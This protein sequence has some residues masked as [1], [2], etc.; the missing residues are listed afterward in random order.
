MKESIRL[1]LAMQRAQ[2]EAEYA[3][4]LAQHDAFTYAMGF[5]RLRPRR[6]EEFR[7]G[8]AVKAAR[9]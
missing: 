4:L 1:Y 6:L 8:V 3:E 5:A 2:T 7:A 9:G